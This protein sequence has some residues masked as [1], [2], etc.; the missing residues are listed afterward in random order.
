M[1]RCKDGENNK[2]ELFK[3]MKEA[4]FGAIRV[5]VTWFNH[6]DKD[7]NV[8]KAAFRA[9]LDRCLA[10]GIR[11]YVYDTRIAG[12]GNIR[13]L[14]RE[15]NDGGAAYRARVR[16]V[17]ADW[18]DHPAGSGFYVALLILPVIVDETV[19]QHVYRKDPKSEKSIVLGENKGGLNQLIETGDILNVIMK[20]VFTDAFDEVV[21]KTDIE[22]HTFYNLANYP[23]DRDKVVEQM[24]KIFLPSFRISY[25]TGPLTG[26]GGGKNRIVFDRINRFQAE[27][28]NMSACRFPEKQT[29][30]YDFGVIEYHYRVLREFFWQV[31][32]YTFTALSIFI[33]QDIIK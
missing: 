9:F 21:T 32:E 13:T 7:G 10:A 1:S 29:C 16:E 27:Y 17:V 6:M 33:N 30:R 18:G 24:K 19:T 31:T 8:D 5:P 28:L 2:P 3:M 25:H 14:I 11:P 23:G 20:D 12:V 4:G 15:K 22:K 26:S